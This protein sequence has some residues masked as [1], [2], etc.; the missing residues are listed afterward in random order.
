MKCINCGKNMGRATEIDRVGGTVFKKKCPVC[1]T[2]NRRIYP[3]YTQK[4]SN[5]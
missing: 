1:G 2:V 4:A 3:G 5:G